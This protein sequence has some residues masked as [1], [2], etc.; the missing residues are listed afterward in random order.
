MRNSLEDDLKAYMKP[1]GEKQLQLFRDKVRQNYEKLSSKQKQFAENYKNFQLQLIAISGGTISVFIA[2]GSTQDVSIFTK[3]GFALL[4][5]SLLFGI[6]SLFFTFESEQTS[7]RFEED[8]TFESEK[9]EL[10]FIEKFNYQDVTIDKNIMKEKEK[11]LKDLK[12]ELEKRSEFTNKILKLLGLDGQKI[13]D[14]QLLF[15][16]TGVAFLIMGLFF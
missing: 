9:M 10:D 4:G 1:Y 11:I 13:E 15:F 14:G 5:L 7:I 6:L 8:F 16:L 3:L 12:R 2:L